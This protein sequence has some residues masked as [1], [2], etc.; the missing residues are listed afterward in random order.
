[1]NSFDL[2]MELLEDVEAP[3]SDAGDFANG[4]IVGVGAVAAVVTIIS[5]T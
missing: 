3:M 4:V 1:M 2:Q 5:F